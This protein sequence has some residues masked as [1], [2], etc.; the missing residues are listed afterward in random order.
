MHASDK[1]SSGRA[2]NPIAAGAGASV[3]AGAGA[4]G[5]AGAGASIAA[6]ADG[7]VAAGAA[8]SIAAVIA[9]LQAIGAELPV[10]N[11]LAYFNRLYLTV[12]QTVR[13]ASESQQFENSVFLERLDVT[14]AGLYFE[15]AATLH[16]GAACPM[17]WRPLISRCQQAHAPVQFALAGMNAHIN[18]DL[19]LA[20]VRTC[21]E[22]G[23]APE[24]GTPQHT[25][26]KR[27]NELL[28]AVEPQV[29]EWFKSGLIADL[30]DV[31]PERVDNALAM[32]SIVAA[33]EL[34]W[35]HAELIWRLREMPE[36]ARGYEGMLARTT[37]AAGWAMLV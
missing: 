2:A 4:S 31:I 15:A 32:W 6:G 25:D 16:N 3:A 27:V 24:P 9:R 5:A 34:A 29:A 13:A 19:P 8:G 14:F 17:A 21:A 30:E 7:P 33:R 23:L 28:R 1:F 10:K 11:G 26:Y 35:N 22:F 18:H 20:V 37:E 12:T 36:L